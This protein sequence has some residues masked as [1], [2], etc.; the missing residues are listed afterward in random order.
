[1]VER[2]FLEMANNL[3]VSE[4]EVIG[5]IIQLKKERVIRQISVIFDTRKLGYKSSLVAMRVSPERLSEAAKVINQHPG[6]SH[7]YERNHEFNLW[8]TIAVPPASSIETHVDRLHE[9]SEAESTRL[10]PTIRLFKIGV[11]LDMTGEEA[12]TAKGEVKYNDASRKLQAPPLTPLDI[13][14]IRELQ[15]DLSIESAPFDPMAQRMGMTTPELLEIANTLTAR[16]YMRRCAAVLHHRKAGFK[17]NGM[18]VWMVPDDRIEEIGTKMAS[19]KI[20]SH[21]YQRPVYPDWP[22]SI[23]TMV[24]GHS[25]D[26]CQRVIDEISSETGINEYTVLYSTRE[27]KKIRLRYFTEELDRWEEQM[28]SSSARS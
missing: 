1:M 10:L 25:T 7:N 26:D 4:E 9:L 14:F 13:M 19:F 2:P 18:G 28:L 22:Y 17:A 5:R 8:F 20:V 15:E 12:I 27:Y 11:Q 6:V 24:H 16:G 23:F 3:E 21:C